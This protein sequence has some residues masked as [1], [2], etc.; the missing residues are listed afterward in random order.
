M[1]IVIAIIDGSSYYPEIVCGMALED[2]KDKMY[3]I[4][5]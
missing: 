3:T 2:V 5:P 1:K 4:D